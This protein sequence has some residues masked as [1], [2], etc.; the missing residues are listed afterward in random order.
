MER[1]FAELQRMEDASEQVM[2]VL[3]ALPEQASAS[4]VPG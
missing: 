1:V 3:I 4:S 2:S